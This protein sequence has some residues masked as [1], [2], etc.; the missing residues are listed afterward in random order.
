[1]DE[2]NLSRNA[3]ISRNE[4]ALAAVLRNLAFLESWLPPIALMI[5]H[6]PDYWAISRHF[7]IKEGFSGF[8]DK[9]RRVCFGRC[10]FDIAIQIGH[11]LFRW[12]EFRAA[13]FVHSHRGRFQ[14]P[15]PKSDSRNPPTWPVK[16]AVPPIGRPNG[17]NRTAKRDRFTDVHVTCVQ[18]SYATRESSP[19]IFEAPPPSRSESLN[20][21]IIARARSESVSP[22]RRFI[23]FMT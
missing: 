15:L 6:C 18:S 14:T 13:R 11:A 8:V 2:G 16:S 7:R 22:K 17:L 10:P 20:G 23:V 21:D 3:Q 19:V 4:C 12:I 1:M 9:S 5:H